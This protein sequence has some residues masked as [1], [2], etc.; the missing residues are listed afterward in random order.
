MVRVPIALTLLSARQYDILRTVEKAQLMLP[1]AWIISAGA[2]I[3][4]DLAAIGIN[5]Q[6][7]RVMA[8]RLSD[9][10]RYLISPGSVDVENRLVGCECDLKPTGWDRIRR[11]ASRLNPLRSKQDRRPGP[12]R[13]VFVARHDMRVPPLQDRQLA[14]HVDRMRR[15]L[16]PLDPVIQEIAAMKLDRLEDIRGVCEDEGGHRTL[17][18]IG[19]DVDTKRRYVIDHMFGSVKITLPQVRIADGLFEMRGL[20]PDRYRAERQH[21]FLRFHVNGRFFGCLLTPEDKVAF[22]LDDVRHLR[23][24]ILLQQALETN[25]EL[26]LCLEACLEG[27]ARALRL[28]LTPEMD[29]DYARNRTP[30]VYQALF[31]TLHLDAAQ[32]QDVIRSLSS[33]KIGVSFSYVSLKTFGDP[34][35]TTSISVLHDVKALEVV[36][37]DVPGLY[38]EISRKA[39]RTEAG[40]YY[41]L[42]SIKGRADEN[43]L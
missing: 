16:Q 39:T 32:Q 19:G 11:A 20:R 34:R 18:K 36:R 40:N 13:Q 22:W 42:E 41:L 37:Q 24:L 23:H 6:P 9:I 8:Y 2:P 1:N 10:G 33:H 30:P 3:D 31:D 17:L 38:A 4:I 25:A 21:R 35:P 12:D 27:E 5:A 43:G 14:R 26:K 15:L 29:I 28:M 7:K